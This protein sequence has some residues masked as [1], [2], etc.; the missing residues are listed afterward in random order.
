MRAVLR[1]S[2]IARTFSSAAGGSKSTVTSASKPADPLKNV[3]GLTTNCLN[4][5]VC[6]KKAVPG[7]G[8]EY[9]SP[10]YFSYSNTS[11]AEAEVE[12]EKFRIAQPSSIQ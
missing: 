6:D 2:Q 7:T 9:K 10:E 4:K 11:Y 12:M 3:S 5:D 8:T 1:L